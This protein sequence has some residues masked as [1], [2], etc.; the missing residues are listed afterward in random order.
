MRSGEVTI[1]RRL[2]FVPIYYKR[3]AAGSI[4][5]LSIKNSGSTGQGVDKIEHFKLLANDRWG[6]SVTI[7]EDLDGE[8]VAGHFRDYLAQR[9]VVGSGNIV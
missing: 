3:L 7:A 5:Y 1:L 4:S 8:D 6:E 2:L 9:L